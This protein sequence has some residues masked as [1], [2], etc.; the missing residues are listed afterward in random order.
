MVLFGSQCRVRSMARMDGMVIRDGAGLLKAADHCIAVGVGEIPPAN[1]LIKQKIS[2]VPMAVDFNDG[3]AG[4]VARKMIKPHINPGDVEGCIP[5]HAVVGVGGGHPLSVRVLGQHKRVFVWA[6]EGD[7]EGFLEGGI[8][9]DMVK[10]SVGIENSHGATDMIEHPLGGFLPRVD[11]QLLVA[12]G[13]DITVGLVAPHGL[14]NER[15]GIIPF[16][17]IYTECKRALSTPDVA[18]KSESIDTLLAYCN[19]NTLTVP[20]GFVPEIFDLPSYGSVCRIVPPRQLPSRKDFGTRS[21]LATLVHAVVHIERSAIDLALDAVYRFPQMPKAYV[22]DWLAVAQ[23]EVRHYHMLHGILERLGHT[24]GDWP[25]HA[26]LFEMSMKTA[27][28]VRDRMAVIPRYFEAGGLDVNPQIARKLMPHAGDPL[29]ADVIDALAVIEAEEIDHVRK[30]DRWFRWLCARDHQE[31]AASFLAILNRYGLRSRQRPHMNV[32]ARKQ[33]GFSC[34]ELL[35]LG[36]RNC[37]G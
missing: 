13:N 33:A 18:S 23:D 11:N 37:S 36:A 21:G 8:A 28:D 9:P 14:A 5:L 19:T 2:T 29:V 6:V 24:Y 26:G 12:D 15:H 30:G 35:E 20:D 1:A 32:A 7:L 17:N 4:R 10:V 31:P 22:V 3:T 34:D 16:M 27:T 25:V